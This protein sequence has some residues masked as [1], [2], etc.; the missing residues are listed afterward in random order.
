MSSATFSEG[1][2]CFGALAPLGKRVSCL[3]FGVW[4]PPLGHRDKESMSRQV[5]SS[6]EIN[7][8]HESQ[9]RFGWTS[10]VLM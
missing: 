8:G 10:G 5:V 3:A 2:E 6:C 1:T 9:R 7:S 4:D